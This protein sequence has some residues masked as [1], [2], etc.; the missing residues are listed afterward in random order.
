MLQSFASKLLWFVLLLA[1]GLLLWERAP[2]L[3][4]VPGAF[5]SPTSKTAFDNWL[6]EDPQRQEEFLDL[7]R[8]LLEN[9]VSGIVPAWQLTRIDAHYAQR[10][11]L[12]VFRVPPGELWPNALPALRLVRD[13]VEPAVGQVQVLS[14]YRTPE[15]N[16][17]ARG[18]SRSNHLEFSALDLATEDRRRG[19]EFYQE[20]C[21]MQDRAGPESRMGLGAYF[22]PAEPDYAGGRFH[23]DGEGYRSWGRSYTSA[24]SP[25]G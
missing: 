6:A 15:L 18:A 5:L 2:G 25:C 8:F 7:E 19:A 3:V 24:S 14:S 17:C 16:Q 13:E 4:R 22:D 21:A 12:P 11:D 1:L 9:E 23:I 10:C 20:L